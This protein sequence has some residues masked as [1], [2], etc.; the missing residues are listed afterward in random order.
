LRLTFNGFDGKIDTWQDIPYQPSG[1]DRVGEAERHALEMSQFK[2]ESE[3]YEE[4]ILMDNFKA[5][6]E[7]I[8]APKY[9]APENVQ[10]AGSA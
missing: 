3:G 2:E 9:E 5:E 6:R 7:S 1:L 4:I 10:N 8:K